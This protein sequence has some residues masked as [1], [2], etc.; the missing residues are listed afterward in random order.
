VGSVIPIQYVG[1]QDCDRAKM[2]SNEALLYALANADDDRYGN[3]GGYAVIHG[4]QPVPD[5]PGASKSFD[6]LAGAFPVLWPYGRGLYHD[7]RR[8]KISFQ[9]YIQ[10]AL[11]YYDRRFRTHHCFPFVAFSIQQ[12]QSALLSAKIRMRRS[13][14]E[15]DCGILTAAHLVKYSIK[16]GKTALPKAHS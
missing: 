4:S 5:L 7:R 12:K 13:D 10:W 8:R 16:N 11:Q 9:E 3:E 6:A 1:V 15:A 14:F 2:T